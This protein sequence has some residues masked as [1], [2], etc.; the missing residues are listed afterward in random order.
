LLNIAASDRL[1]LLYSVARLLAKHHIVVKLAKV[2][3][4][5]ERVEDTSVIYAA[6]L[7]HNR[8]QIDI[9]TEWLKAKKA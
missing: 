3:T 6:E 9:E 2:V 4:L 7:Q 8:A 1:G 5:D